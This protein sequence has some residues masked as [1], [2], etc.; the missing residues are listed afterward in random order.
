MYAI[1]GRGIEQ[2]GS[3]FV[4]LFCLFVLLLFPMKVASGHA[5]GR[6]GKSPALSD[7]PAYLYFSQKAHFSFSPVTCYGYT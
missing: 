6:H 5:H 3:L 4:C 2:L 7:S 1:S